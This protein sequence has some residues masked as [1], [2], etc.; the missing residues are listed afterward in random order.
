MVETEV[1]ALLL[2]NNLIKEHQPRFNIEL[3]DDKTYPSIVIRKERFPRVHA[4]RQVIRNGSE[5]FG[6]YASVKTMHAVLDIVR[7]L[8]PVRTCKYDLSEKNIDAGKFRT[9][10][11][12]DMGNCLAP[13]VGKQSQADYDAGIDAIR[14]ILRG[15]IKDLIRDQDRAMKTAAA[16]FAFE[17]AERH[18]RNKQALEKFQA[19]S[20][21]VHP[22]I[23]DVEVYS[24]VSD[25]TSG[26]V[27][28]MKIMNGGIVHGQTLEFRKRSTKATKSCWNTAFRVPPAAQLHS[29]EIFTSIPV[30]AIVEDVKWHVPRRGDK[31]RLIELSERNAKYTMLDRRKQQEQVDPEAAQ[32]RIMETLQKDLHL[33]ELPVHIECFDN[34]NIQGTHPASACVVFKKAKPSKA[35]YR[36]FNIKTV[37]GPDDFASM[38]EV[39]H[40]RYKRLL[41]EGEPLPQLIIVDGG[42]GQ[43]S[44]AVGAL[45]QLDLIGK[46]AII[47]IAKRL[48]ELYFPGDSIPLHSASGPIAQAHPAHAG[49]GAPLLP[50]PPPE[51]PQR[52]RPAQ[53][54]GRHPRRRSGHAAQADGRIRHGR[55]H[56]DR[57]RGRPAQGGQ[58]AGGPGHP[59]LGFRG[60]SKGLRAS[61]ALDPTA[62]SP[63]VGSLNADQE[64]PGTDVRQREALHAR[65]H[66]HML[67]AAA[68][69][70]E[71]LEVRTCRTHGPELKLSPIVNRHEGQVEHIGRSSRDVG[72]TRQP[73]NAVGQVVANQNGFGVLTVVDESGSDRQH[74]E[75][76]EHVGLHIEDERTVFDGSG[77]LR[78]T[79]VVVVVSQRVDF[80]IGVRRAAFE[81]DETV[82]CSP[83]PVHARHLWSQRVIGRPGSGVRVVVV[84]V[85]AHMEFQ[86]LHR[87]H[88]GHAAQ[89]VQSVSETIGQHIGFRNGGLL[90]SVM[91]NREHTEVVLEAV[92]VYRF[93]GRG[94][95]GERR[96][97]LRLTDT[98][99]DAERHVGLRRQHRHQAD[100]PTQDK[101]G[102][103][104]R[105][106]TKDNHFRWG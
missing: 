79:G 97:H 4:T 49:R 66:I 33:K 67:D 1:D 7:K 55:R 59:D 19:K 88:P 92:D 42:K 80:E 95:H 2:E 102:T 39:V 87:I 24:V 73:E 22:S 58:P 56:Q 26:Y 9:C 74:V 78:L 105:H 23:H 20:T 50:V 98:V 60:G 6:P 51:T 5:Y 34:S 48:E 18:K 16:A 31:K 54:L 62:G 10:L 43:L 36:K 101:N 64:S 35:D 77:H 84:R 69:E 85:D 25:P 28:F 61:S 47:G 46:V 94:F 104:G 13:C 32:N 63:A 71:Q 70:V 30:R 8:H 29:P 100:D 12:Y 76:P 57:P 45:A 96:R 93:P 3:K 53:R 106:H 86:G 82:S 91:D 15:N 11:E 81:G 103:Q 52:R 68:Q 38:A 83:P 75:E 99:I 90:P 44:S 72:C 17:D 65:G 40:R 21:V 37:E 41:D 89:G 14:T 27:N